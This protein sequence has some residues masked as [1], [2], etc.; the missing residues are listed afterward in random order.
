[1]EDRVDFAVA[2]ETRDDSVVVR[3]DGE[4]DMAN[5]ASF[6]EAFPA[7]EDASH[8]VVDLSGCTFLDSAGTRAL[9]SAVRQAE[10]LSIVATDPGVLRVLEITALDTMVAIH[11]SLDA[12]LAR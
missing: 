2:V 6:E 3:V 11:P 12:A 8:V 4:L 1:V 5:A 7:S 10:Q 9:A